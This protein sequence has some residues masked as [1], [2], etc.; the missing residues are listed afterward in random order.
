MRD[1]HV[2]IT[3]STLHFEFKGKS[4]KMHKFDL[5]DRRLT[6]IVSRY[7]DRP[8][9]ELFHYVD[10]NGDRVAI[11]SGMVNQCLREITHEDITAKD[12]RTW[13]GTVH[14]AERM[15]AKPRAPICAAWLPPSDAFFV[16]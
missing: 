12:F 5:H 4:G 16:Y 2:K 9:Y 6:V 11:D 7:R 14:A 8:G 3:G 1:Q 10:E 13:H 15:T